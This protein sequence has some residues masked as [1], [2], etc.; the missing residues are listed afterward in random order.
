MR[1]FLRLR[2]S[3]EGENEILNVLLLTKGLP[4]V[5]T[6]KYTLGN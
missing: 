1:C 5:R 6:E 3:I 2:A 4:E